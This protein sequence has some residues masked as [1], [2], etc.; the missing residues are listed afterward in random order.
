MTRKRRKEKLS[1][2]VARD[3]VHDIVERNL[4]VGAMLP[5]E[6]E[7]F[8]E[9]GVGRASVRE[10]LRLLE[11]NG[12]ITIKTG[13]KGG[14]MVAQASSVEF[15]KT[16]TLYF[17]SSRATFGELVEARI[18]ME[19]MMAALAAHR[20]SPETEHA[21][22]ESLDLARKAVEEGDERLSLEQG[23]N[24]HGIIAS[25]SGNRVLDFFG[26]A[27]KH[28][29][30]ERLWAAGE[31]HRPDVLDDHQAVA[32]AILEGDAERAQRLMA[33]HMNQ[34]YAGLAEH[35]DRLGDE[36]IDWR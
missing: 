14:P 5:T 19:P 24:F 20:R 33:E 15:A 35:L 31:A 32:H 21:L 9:Y 23:A 36:L 17:H 10:A 18:V 30:Y 27:L 26:G 2:G 8:E 28:I 7:M 25:L 13:P 4:P 22:R 12:L 16:A 6:V 11:V 1:E 34:I 3:I 29:Y